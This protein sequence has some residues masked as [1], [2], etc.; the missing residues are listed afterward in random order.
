MEQ[1]KY[2]GPCF[3][4]YMTDSCQYYSFTHKEEEEEG[5]QFVPVHPEI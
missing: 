5:S 1:V 2:N 3:A 4:P